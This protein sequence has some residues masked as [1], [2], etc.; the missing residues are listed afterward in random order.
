MTGERGARS[1]GAAELPEGG[2][3]FTPSEMGAFGGLA[4]EGH[5]LTS[6]FT[7]PPAGDQTG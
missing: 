3:G 7:G 6:G 1:W 5:D 4:E 2:W